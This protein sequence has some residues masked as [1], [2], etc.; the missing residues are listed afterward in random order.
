[1]HREIHGA[2]LPTMP[3]IECFVMHNSAMLTDRFCA[4]VFTAVGLGKGVSLPQGNL[5]G[6]YVVVAI[7]PSVWR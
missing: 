2:C 5:K 1:M 7:L 6:E 3:T 4:R